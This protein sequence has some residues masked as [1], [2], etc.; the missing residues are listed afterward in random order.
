MAVSFR[1]ARASSSNRAIA[2]WLLVCA[3]SV[4][5]MVVIGGITR[6]T[7]SGLSIVEW[8]PVLGALP[9]LTD[10]AWQ[11]AFDAYRQSPE[12]RIVNAGMTLDAFKSIFLV[13][14]LHRL[15]GRAV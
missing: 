2:T 4:M 6:L 15:A 11:D 8:S 14:W 13:E 7:R 10:G 9:P 5:A 12:G 1:T 3:A